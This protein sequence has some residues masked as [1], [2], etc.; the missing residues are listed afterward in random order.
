VVLW[1][2]PDVIRHEARRREKM[3]KKRNRK[4]MHAPVLMFFPESCE[5]NKKTACWGGGEGE[6]KRSNKKREGEN[7][8]VWGARARPDLS[9]GGWKE[10][11][12]QRKK[13][14]GK[15]MRARESSRKSGGRKR[16]L[17]LKANEGN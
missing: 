14:A 7:K 9:L 8:R 15:K 5:S 12:N 10:N 11:E 4:K 2:R 17:L 1:A 16:T 3:G 6:K 13:K